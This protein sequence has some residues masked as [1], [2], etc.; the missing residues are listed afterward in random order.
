[1]Y[2]DRLE[3]E[4][5][6]FTFRSPDGA[7][8][9]ARVRVEG[10]V[11]VTAVGALAHLFEGQRVACSGQWVA[12]PRWGRQFKVERVLVQEPRTLRGL[13]KYLVAAIDGVGPELARR[14]VE[15]FGLD[16]LEVLD[17]APERLTEVSGIGA[18]TRERIVGAWQAGAAGRELMVTLGGFGLGPAVCRRVVDRFG[19]DALAVVARAPYRLTEVRGIG[20]RTADQIARANGIDVNDPER[21]AA[22]IAF[23][24]EEG[25]EEG[26]CFLPE[27]VLL[28][29]LGRLDVGRAP[30]GEQL[31]VL[32]A[33]GRVT[34]HRA[35]LEEA[36]PVYRTATD[37]MEARV[38][39]MLR[40]RAD[41]AFP[42]TFVDVRAVEARVGLELDEGQRAA[43]DLALGSSVCVVTGGPGTGKTTIVRVLLA[44]GKARGERWLLAAP[45]GRAARRLSGTT[46]AEAKTIHRLLEYSM[47]DMDFTRNTSNPLEADGVLIDE[48]SMLDLKLTH[49]LLDALPERCRLVLV[50]DVDQLP[51][52]GAGQV[53]RDCID[54]GGVPVARLTEV[55][56][57]ARHSGIVRNAHRVN[58][59]ELPISAEREPVE[60]GASPDAP[61]VTRDFFVL[62]RED[63]GDARDLLLQVVAERLPR[64]GFDPLRDVQVLTPM[65]AGPLGTVAL[66]EALGAALNPPPSGEAEAQPSLKVGGR[67]FRL[68]DRVLQTKNDYDNDI[69]NGDVGSVV[70]VE[71]ASLT[72]DFDGRL[73]T[74]SGDALDALDHAFAM[75]IHKSQGSE[76][77]A[78]VIA[79]HASHFVMLRRNLLYTAITRAQRF[80]CVVTSGRALRTAVGRSGGDE[81]HTGLA[82]RLAGRPVGA[83]ASAT[84]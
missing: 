36:R 83:G 64:N 13:E 59:G 66:N 69:F 18:R 30:A 8:A 43:V 70:A 63:A 6:G 40:S 77:P 75:S 3:G 7:F 71:G 46:G 1:M 11:E 14:I 74:L 28:A 65:H 52:V 55:Y 44:G 80:C 9:V 81:R 84:R 41:A 29:R 68:R 47:Q 22:A 4:I 23:C 53:L 57:Q 72:I 20:F 50:G 31:D 21:I 76:Y 26:S 17:R 58:R 33:L 39:S 56:R 12:D 79:L 24:L 67:I 10:A 60:E 27:G 73:V 51:S 54:S 82:D 15:T 32:A 5:S 62:A 35:S 37:R 48:S 34:R 45:T 19:K 38:A 78:V 49:A 16:A 25:E 2:S 42:A 61:P